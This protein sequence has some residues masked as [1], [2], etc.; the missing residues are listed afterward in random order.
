MEVVILSAFMK[1]ILGS[2]KNPIIQE[3]GLITGVKKELKNLESIFWTI[4]AVL[5]DAEEQQSKNKAITDWLWKL[6][7][8]AYDA[9]DVFI[10]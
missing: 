10:R 3:Y 5:E 9:D 4:E 2:F 7:D 8:A 6:K 1:E